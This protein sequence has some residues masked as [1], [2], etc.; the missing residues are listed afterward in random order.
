[1]GKQEETE[2]LVVYPQNGSN[3]PLPGKSPRV[4]N[5]LG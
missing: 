1:M 4:L 5:F 3:Y 2:L